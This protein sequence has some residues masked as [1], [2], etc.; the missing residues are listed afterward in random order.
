MSDPSKNTFMRK[1]LIVLAVLLGL[2]LCVWL[3]WPSGNAGNTVRLL[4]WVG[5]DEA[6]LWREFRESS[7]IDVAVKTYIGGTAMLNELKKNPDSYDVVVLDPEFIALAHQNNL[8]DSMDRDAFDFSEYHPFFRELSILEV[9]EQLVA[10]PVRFGIIGLLYNADRVSPE[11]T[12]SY[13]SILKDK[14]KNRV[15]VMNLWQSTMGTVSLSLG[16]SKKPYGVSLDGLAD[17]EERLT[18]LRSHG[19]RVHNAVPDLL[20]CLEDEVTWIML[21]GGEANAAS[22]QGR[23]KN[24]KWRVPKEGG[25]LWMESLGIVKNTPNRNNAMKVIKFLQSAT[26]QALLARRKTYISSPPSLDACQLLTHEERE[27]RHIAS[28]EQMTELLNSVVV[29]ELPPSQM[30]KEWTDVWERFKSQ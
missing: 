1:C 11:D 4:A 19:I 17:I 5:Y 12:E 18:E 28:T 29:R 22:L 10:V 15:S 7:G 25:I 21:G 27:L 6:D 13:A 9:E 3:L 16:N 14:Y 20:G 26:G 30:L 2:V 23:G 8:L 24:F